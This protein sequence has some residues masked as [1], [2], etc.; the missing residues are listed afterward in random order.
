MK[1]VG[2]VVPVADGVVVGIEVLGVGVVELETGG[3]EEDGTGVPEVVGVE[4]LL[5]VVASGGVFSV[6]LHPAASAM[7]AT[8][9]PPAAMP[10]R[11]RNCLLEN[12]VTRMLVRFPGIL[13]LSS[14]IFTILDHLSGAEDT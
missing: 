3:V 7:D 10:T 9:A 2:T 8:A 1:P 6:D 4:V 14:D 13:F 5:P 12:F 11:L